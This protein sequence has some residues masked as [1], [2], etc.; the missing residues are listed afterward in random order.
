MS[1]LRDGEVQ[2]IFK[3]CLLDRA[4]PIYIKLMIKAFNEGLARDKE[5]EE[6]RRIKKSKL[7]PNSPYRFA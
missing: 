3:S 1:K 7:S 6:K 5:E 2:H 4:V